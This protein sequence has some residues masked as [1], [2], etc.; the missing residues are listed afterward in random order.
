MRIPSSTVLHSKLFLAR[1][2]NNLF[3]YL[4]REYKIKKSYLGFGFALNDLENNQSRFPTTTSQTHFKISESN[5]ITLWVINSIIIVHF[6][7]VV[8]FGRKGCFVPLLLKDQIK[9]KKH[10]TLLPLS[11]TITKGM[12][13][14]DILYYILGIVFGLQSSYKH[15]ETQR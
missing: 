5:I 4:G 11:Q 14:H 3:C 13:A 9:E 7:V 8:E 12:G 15:S 2:Y 1:E 6:L 10:S